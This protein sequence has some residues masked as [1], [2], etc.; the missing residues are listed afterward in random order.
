MTPVQRRP[1]SAK[2]RWKD[3]G[4]DNGDRE[5]VATVGRCELFA[6]PGRQDFWEWVVQHPDHQCEGSAPD[7]ERAK[8]C[9]EAVAKIIGG[10]Q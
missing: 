10:A 1:S 3:N 2:V 8:S 7:R 6:N 5:W 9:A 4:A